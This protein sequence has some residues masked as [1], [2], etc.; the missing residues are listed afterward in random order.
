[1]E[2]F[3]YFL[4]FVFG[5]IVGSFLNVV[6]FRYHSGATFLGRSMCFSCGKSLAWH[7]LVPV[8]S[9]FA[10]AG[11]CRFCRSKIS[12]HYAVIEMSTGALFALVFW[13]T[14][15]VSALQNTASFSYFANLFLLFVS[16]SL[17][18]VI[19]G[20]DLKHKIIPDTFAYSFAFLSLF[21]LMA[22]PQ[23]KPTS[24]DFLAGP[25]LA[26]PFAFLWYVSGGR[27]MGLGDAKLA[28]GIG[29]FLGL[30]AGFVAIILAFWIGAIFGLALI[31][32]EKMKK[33]AFFHKHITM[34]SEIPF[35]PFLIIGLLFTFFVP[36]IM[37]AGITLLY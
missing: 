35:A 4:V 19:G 14:G 7:D 10:L 9:F 16:M 3:I 12:W 15:G 18:A 13:K 30:K 17:L 34:K 25:I 26:F 24:L 6:I 29:W 28:L 36:R 32:V 8:F 5:A 23:L 31:A 22:F 2:I 21:L 37:E 11:K 1:M 20:Y 27:W 33:A